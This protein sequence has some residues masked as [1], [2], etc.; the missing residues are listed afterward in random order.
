MYFFNTTKKIFVLVLV[1]SCLFSTIPTPLHAQLAVTDPVTETNTGAIAG[2]A[3]GIQASIAAL[4]PPNNATAAVS[5]WEKI[6]HNFLDPIAWAVAKKIVAKMTASTVNWINSGFKG[7]PG[8]IT[9]PGQFFLDAGDSALSDYITNNPGLNSLCSPFEAKVKI[10]L[11]RNRLNETGNNASCSLDKIKNNFESFMSDF[12]QGGW[13]GW[14][15]VSQRDENN[16]YGSYLKAKDTAKIVIGNK[17]NKYQKQVD[18][19]GGILSFEKCKASSVVTQKM[20]D[21]NK[22]L[23]ASGSLSP[24]KNALRGLKAGDCLNGNME[25]VT[26][27]STINGALSKALGSGID[28]LNLADSFDEIIGSL[29]NSLFN[30]VVGQLGGGGL[31]GA[32][33]K[34]SLA[35]NTII[36]E[37]SKPLISLIGSEVLNV[38][39]GL[40]FDDP[41]A[42]ATDQNDGE[43][44]TYIQVTG[45]YDTSTVGS[46]TLT[47]NVV[48]SQGVAADPVTRIINVMVDVSAPSAFCKAV[49]DGRGNDAGA[50]STI[51]P[52][53]V[54]F[55]QSEVS[56][57]KQTATLNKVT[58]AD[59]KIQMN[60]TY[61][62]WTP[63][64]I[65]NR[66]TADT[67][68]SAWIFVW[69]Y[70]DYPDIVISPSSLAEINI[71]KDRLA[72]QLD[73][74][75]QIISGMR[76]AAAN[77]VWTVGDGIR[78][79]T[80]NTVEW[81]IRHLYDTT[82]ST[83]TLN[84]KPNKKVD[85]KPYGVLQT[86]VYEMGAVDAKLTDN[87]DYI[88]KDFISA[89]SATWQEAVGPLI[90]IK[91]DFGNTSIDTPYLKKVQ[92]ELIGGSGK[93]IAF[94]STIQSL[95]DRINRAIYI[96]DQVAQGKTVSGVWKGI[97]FTYIKTT[98]PQDFD[99]DAIFCADPGF[100]PTPGENYGFMVSTPANNNNQLNKKEKSNILMQT[101]PNI[102]RTAPPQTP[103]PTRLPPPPPTGGDACQLDPN[104]E[105]RKQSQD[106]LDFMMP[107]LNDIP[108]DNP[109]MTTP[110]PPSASYQSAV[111]NIVDQVNKRYPLVKAAYAGTEYVKENTIAMVW[112]YIVGPVSA[113]SG[114]I[115]HQ[116]N[117]S[118]TIWQSAWRVTSP[119]CP[120][121]GGGGGG[122]CADPGNTTPN[123]RGAV[124]A[125]I[126]A[127]VS[128]NP[129][130]ASSMNTMS[131]SINFASLVAA[132]LQSSG[133]QATSNVLSGNGVPHTENYV[134]V[135]SASDNVMERYEIVNQAGDGKSTLQSASSNPQY[136]GDIPL[137]CAG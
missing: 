129:A 30:Q 93:L 2:S 1:I 97:P 27:G 38:Q 87:R 121:S 22:A 39:V 136:S 4:I 33:S 100:K 23:E 68:G 80:G 17:E 51:D 6:K 112:T 59:P 67:I 106:A 10:A 123:Y 35:Q 84:L 130:L 69:R 126:S 96:A 76:A 99:T 114:K 24:E 113:S 21:D 37:S 41:G 31:R 133:Y 46:Y 75:D 52:R 83:T 54:V 36:R 81:N 137:S 73:V 79:G 12:K 92:I 103:I 14:L 72:E 128:N 56:I 116:L 109:L 89:Q 19:G 66:P 53:D 86:A 63:I 7:N 107:L 118:Q 61:R 117:N 64:S 70:Q 65:G 16:E 85:F 3:T 120:G 74:V 42:I 28:Q 60:Y 15:E 34:N 18:T 122:K 104:A 48:N 105:E 58:L 135:W 88:M 40:R 44:S 102:T 91:Q 125:A 9:D 108:V 131:N 29:I 57:W 62:G 20:I 82:Y 49:S 124:Q 90:D 8:Y 78:L 119:T 115:S 32:G 101:W 132:Q 95:I 43:I 77:D 50:P 98:S 127:V 25:T 110:T 45:F 47:Y 11:V 134:A 71:L 26:P 5:I 111:Q 94:Q 55:D 13:D